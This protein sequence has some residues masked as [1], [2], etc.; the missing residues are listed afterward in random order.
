ME[1]EMF[2]WRNLSHTS[3]PFSSSPLGK[4]ECQSVACLSTL[5]FLIGVFLTQEMEDSPCTSDGGG[6]V[7]DLHGSSDIAPRVLGLWRVLEIFLFFFSLPSASS[8]SSS[9]P[10][11]LSIWSSIVLRTSSSVTGVSCSSS[12]SSSFLGL[13]SSLVLEQVFKHFVNLC[14]WCKILTI[15]HKL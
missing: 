2:W 6:G 4:P 11:F 3:A 15:S 10:L 8:S 14:W 7:G 12:F 1:V 5:D 9:L 13:S